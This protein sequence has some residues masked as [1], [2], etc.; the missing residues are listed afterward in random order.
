LGRWAD[1]TGQSAQAAGNSVSQLGS[2]W[3]TAKNSLQPPVDVPDKPWYNDAL[4]WNT[5]YDKALEK[6]QSVDSVNMQVFNT[7]AEQAERSGW[8]AQSRQQIPRCAG[9]PRRRGDA[10][11]GTPGTRGPG[12]PGSGRDGLPGVAASARRVPAVPPVIGDVQ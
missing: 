11:P 3:S 1:V 12:A 7:Y 5:D 4:P 9:I 2:A 10:T 6:S 8:R